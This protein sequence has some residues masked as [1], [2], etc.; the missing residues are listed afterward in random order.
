MKKET[1]FD[2]DAGCYI[3][4]PSF[5]YPTEKELL[6]IFLQDKKII[7]LKLEDWEKSKRQLLQKWVK[8][9]LKKL[10][11]YKDKFTR[12]FYWETLKVMIGDDLGKMND[13]IQILKRLEYI[14]KNKGKKGRRDRESFREIVE[15][16]RNTSI[17]DVVSTLVQL[18]KVGKK[19]VSL[20]PLHKERS[21]S[22]YI[23]PESNSFYC[24]GCNRGGDLIKFV[25]L[26]FG[27]DFKQAVKYLKGDR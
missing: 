23:Y 8:P 17:I 7:P 4:I 15:Q 20:C 11:K 22:F 19:Y 13:N 2:E 27:Y 6:E 25:E 21:P 26:Y 24:F 18:K 12:W 1:Y 10:R 14:S 5:N 16:I 9:Y 3:E